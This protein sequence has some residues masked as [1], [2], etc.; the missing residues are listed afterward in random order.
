MAEQSNAGP[1]PSSAGASTTAASLGDAK[2]P[3]PAASASASQSMADTGYVA[4]ESAPGSTG[5][6]DLGTRG[7]E[8]THI[9][10]SIIFYLFGLVFV[11]CSTILRLT[12]IVDD[13]FA[14]IPAMLGSLILGLGMIRNAWTELRAGAPASFT[15]AALAILAAFAA[16]LYEVAGYVAF[17]L[18]V[19]NHALTRTAWGARRAIEE[20][21]GLTPDAARIVVD[22]AEQD[23][24][25]ASVKVGD[26]V[27][28]RPGE[29]LPVDGEIVKGESSVNQASLTGEALPVEVQPG[30]Q[31]YAGTTNLTGVIDLRT[32]SVGEDTT[33]G[34]VAELI[35]EAEN[36]RTPRQLLIEQVARYFIPIALATSGLVW[37]FTQSA[38][39]AIAVL[40]V[41]CPASLLLASP[42]AMMAAFAA[43]ARLGIMIKRTNYLEAAVDADTFVFDK[44]GTLTTGNFAVAR[45]APAEGVDGAALLQAAADAEQSSTHPLARSIMDTANRARI[46][47]DADLRAEEVFGAGVRAS[48]D[49]VLILAGR[50][51][52]IAGEH[53]EARQQIDAV[54]NQIDGMSGVHVYKDGRYLGAVGLE[55]KLRFNAKGVVHKIRELG[56]RSVILMTGD[57][58]AVAKRVGRTVKVDRIEAECLPE[59]KHKLIEEMTAQGRRVLM[60]GDGINDGPSLAAADVGVAMGLSGS[61]IATNSAGVALMTDDISRVPF[62]VMLA[63]RTRAVITQNVAVSI[64]IAIVGLAL[65]AFGEINIYYALIFYVAALAFVAA[66]SAR[67]VRFGEEFTNEEI[68]VE[69]ASTNRPAASQRTKSAHLAA[70]A[71]G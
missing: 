9:E 69:P 37:Y 58:F 11:V 3:M 44:T 42:T 62:L 8:E 64:L 63:R 12:G 40:I 17:I 57:R 52:W 14:V 68:A 46:K 71:A 27:R 49:G 61:D 18:L 34:K 2:Q 15:L 1:N 54:E 28:V 6:L 22:G 50:P 55:D 51:D 4:E 16:S 32:T 25:L 60:V 19:A 47:P 41:V 35:H 21:A 24:P 31:V 29:N 7:Q 65:A 59:E 67:L 30:N 70:P 43:A 26:L 45:L 56:G 5:P 48:R 38:E 23:V 13:S 36:A 33:I 53:P 10:R 20:L 66:N 39:R